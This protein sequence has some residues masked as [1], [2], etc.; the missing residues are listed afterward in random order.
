MEKSDAVK[1]YV[2][3]AA[4]E[5]R[6]KAESVLPV[7]FVT[8]SRQ[9]GAGG[10]AFAEAFLRELAQEPGREL[11]HGW[12]AFD[13]ALCDKVASDAGLRVI[14]DA[15]LDERFRGSVEDSVTQFMAGLSPQLK[16]YHHMFRTIRTLATVGKAVIVGRAAACFTRDLPTGIHIRLVASRESRILRL[17]GRLGVSKRDAER[18]L[19]ALDKSREA[20][21]REYF[22][23]DIEDPMLYDATWNTDMVPVE[24]VARCV[25]RLVAD[26]AVTAV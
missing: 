14:R 13:Q 23:K 6:P 7:P 19:D 22:H 8:V 24:S 26:R 9:A 16:V 1:K 15:I 11:Y 12:E 20:L 3:T 5:R 10:H 25:L 2:L 21:V 17:S 4:F 18:R